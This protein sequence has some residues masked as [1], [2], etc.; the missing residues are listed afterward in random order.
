MEEIKIAIPNFPNYEIDIM[1]NVHSVKRGII[2]KPYPN[3]NGY[4][5]VKLYDWKGHHQQFFV[6][7]LVFKTFTGANKL[8]TNK[9]FI[10][11]IDRNNTNNRLMNLRAVTRVENNNNRTYKRNRVEPKLPWEMDL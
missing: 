1:G 4:L 3:S 5:R 7:M 10:D 6:H 8:E 11:H 2:L 9:L